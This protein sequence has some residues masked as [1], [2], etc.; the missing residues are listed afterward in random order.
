[1]VGVMFL[2]GRYMVNTIEDD[3]P[4]NKLPREIGWGAI[5]Q[6]TVAFICA[7]LSAIDAIVEFEPE[8]EEIDNSE[9]KA[10]IEDLKTAYIEEMKKINDKNEDE[11]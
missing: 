5:I 1:V 4:Y 3:M 8:E 10:E 11:Q 6:V 7:I 9:T 2:F